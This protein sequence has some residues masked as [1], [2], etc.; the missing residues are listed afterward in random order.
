MNRR[1]KQLILAMVALLRVSF[2]GI[3][4]AT[5]AFTHQINADCRTCHFQGMHA[6]N[7]FGRDFKANAFNLS[8]PMK[9]ELEK[10][11]KHKMDA[12]AD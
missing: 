6:L 8:E 1:I 4:S 10:N 12:H 9:E 2:A 11:N 7:Q 3:A 5:P